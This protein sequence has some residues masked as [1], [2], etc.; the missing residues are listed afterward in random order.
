[1]VGAVK[2]QFIDRLNP[3]HQDHE[4]FLWSR[5]GHKM[6]KIHHKTMRFHIVDFKRF[7]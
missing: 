4:I 3:F 7:Y 2:K 6:L 5:H 1:V